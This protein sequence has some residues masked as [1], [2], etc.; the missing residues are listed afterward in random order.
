M[1]RPEEI[2]ILQRLFCVCRLIAAG[3]PERVV[4]L[5]A[6]LA[7]ALQINAQIFARKRKVA[8]FRRPGRCLRVNRFAEAFLGLAARDHHLPG[9]AV[10]P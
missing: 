3:N 9:L 1:R 6:A 7:A 5:K 10:A 8:V 2:V 4:E